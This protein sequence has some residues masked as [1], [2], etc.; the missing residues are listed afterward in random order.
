MGEE[1]GGS[2]P[3]ET[4]CEPASRARAWPLGRLA[5]QVRALPRLPISFRNALVPAGPAGVVHGHRQE[6][7]PAMAVG[8]DRPREPDAAI[9]G[10]PIG[11]LQKPKG[12]TADRT[13]HDGSDSRKPA[14]RTPS[15]AT[16]ASET[17]QGRTSL[18]ASYASRPRGT[19]VGGA[20][21]GIER[22][23]ARRTV[24]CTPCSAIGFPRFSPAKN[25]GPAEGRAIAFQGAHI[26]PLSA[27]ISDEGRRR[28]R[29]ARSSARACRENPI[30]PGRM[31]RATAMF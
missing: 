12:C 26:R 16:T 27:P 21:D 1:P 4:A 28:T 10:G 19:R 22:G 9:V 20:Q 3:W 15:A 8:I 7:E 17:L 23:E 18:R 11:L 30:L 24:A 6:R 29:H 25:A 2:F 5:R 13:D 31:G 14:C